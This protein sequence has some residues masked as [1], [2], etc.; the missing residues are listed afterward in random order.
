MA[1]LP[2]VDPDS[3]A[4][5]FDPQHFNEVHGPLEV[6]PFRLPPEDL[7]T[8]AMRAMKLRI[9]IVEKSNEY[10]APELAQDQQE[11]PTIVDLGSP[12]PRVTYQPLKTDQSGQ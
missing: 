8:W 4:P 12:Y 5:L 10:L 3:W 11:S 2:A 1:A 7:E 6:E 9:C